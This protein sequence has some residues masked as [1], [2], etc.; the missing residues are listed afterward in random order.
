MT[1]KEWYE[2]LINMVDEMDITDGKRKDAKDFLT[3]ELDLL[4][5]KSSKT[6]PTKKQ[7]ENTELKDA[8]VEVL[9]SYS[10]PVSF[11]DFKTNSALPP[12]SDQKLS[13]LLRQLVTEMKVIRT[14]EKRHP[15]YSIGQ[16][17][18]VTN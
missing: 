14:E 11:S 4:N 1:K 3:H 12:M 5:R 6:T 16:Y 15:F 10:D 8:I 13:A 7:R 9:S 2:E 18:K 17:G